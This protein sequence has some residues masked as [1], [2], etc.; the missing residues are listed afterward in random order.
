MTLDYTETEK[1]IALTEKLLPTIGDMLIEMREDPG[2]RIDTKTGFRDLVTAADLVSEKRILEFLSEQFPSDGLLAEESGR[3]AEGSSGFTWVID[4]VD[5]TVNYA[6]SIPL[7]AI[8]AGLAWKGV[9][10]AG[11]IYLPV[12]REMYKGIIKKGSYKNGRL[13]KVSPLTDIKNAVIVTG[14]PYDRSGK[15]DGLLSGVRSV[16]THATGIRR[17]GSAALDLCW[18]AEGRFDG[19][20]EPGLS[21][22]D[23]AAAVVIAGEAGAVITD[24]KGKPYDPFKSKGIAAA[25][26]VLHPQL[27]DIT[28][29]FREALGIP[30]I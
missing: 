18:I 19:Y 10:V 26:P 29:E 3:T 24:L 21:P 8:S 1:R 25:N 4:P 14:F 6:H 2:L 22:W 23:T 16:L 7:Y 9:P 17:T 30:E 5:G 27:M 15:I 28:E 13:L 12:F 20:Y 11:L